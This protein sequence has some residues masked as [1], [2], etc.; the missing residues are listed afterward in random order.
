VTNAR[1]GCYGVRLHYANSG[2][3]MGKPS[4]DKDLK[5]VVQLEQATHS[6]SLSLAKPGLLLIFMTGAVATARL[7]IDA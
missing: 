5:K 7:S 4:L 3:D 6:L 1:Q 2:D